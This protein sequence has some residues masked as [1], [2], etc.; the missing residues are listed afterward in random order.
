MVDHHN[1]RC[2]NCLLEYDYLKIKTQCKL[3]TRPGTRYC[4]LN[5]HDALKELTGKKSRSDSSEE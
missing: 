1:K 2:K 4:L 3:G 5:L